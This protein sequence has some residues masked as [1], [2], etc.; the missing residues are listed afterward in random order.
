[1]IEIRNNVLP[2]SIYYIDDCAIFEDLQLSLLMVVILREESLKIG[3]FE[4]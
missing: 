4:S 2:L 3:V 1:M